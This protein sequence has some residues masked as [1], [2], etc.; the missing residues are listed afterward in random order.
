MFTGLPEMPGRD[1]WRTKRVIK[2]LLKLFGISR[3]VLFGAMSK[4]WFAVGGAVTVLLIMYYFSPT[5]QGFYFTFSSLLSL[6]LF[7]EMG[8]NS[9]IINFTSHEW[10]KL[11]LDKE[12]RITGDPVALSRLKSLARLV[13]MWYLI[14]AALLA[15]ILIG[16]GSYFFWR[17][18]TAGIHWAGPWLFLCLATGINLVIVP[19]FSLLEG[20]NQVAQ[21]YFFRF[22]QEMVRSLSTW[23]FIIF[24]GGLWTL[25]GSSFMMAICGTAFMLAKFRNYFISLWKVK[26]KAA[27]DWRKEI[28]PMQWRIAVSFMAGY[29]FF[30]LFTPLLFHYKGAVEAGRAGMTIAM[31]SALMLIASMWLITKAPQFGVLISKKSYK[32]LDR[33]LIHSGIRAFLAA[34]GGAIIL[35]TSVY[36]LYSTGSPLSIRL[37]PPLPT[38]LFLAAA[39][40][41]QILIAQSTFLR[42]HKKEPFMGLSVTGAVIMAILAFSTVGRWGATGIAVSYFSLIAF[43]TIPFGTIIWLRCRNEWRAGDFIEPSVASDGEVTI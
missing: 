1:P 7:I 18:D 41:M 12:G 31:T 20:S 15:C 22:A 37:L 39:V 2:K 40:L 34:L 17:S 10:A 13:F 28:W 6:Q 26:V 8:L 4:V 32:E 21:V 3:A 25:G 33:L 23:F 30:P 24:G 14:G 42:A 29:F 36:V 35:F 27:I 5:L 9:V 16:A 43:F 11:S 38:G 19:A